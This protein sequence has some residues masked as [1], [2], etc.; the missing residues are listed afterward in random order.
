MLTIGIFSCGYGHLASQ[1]IESVLSQTVMPEQILFFDDGIWD[2]KHLPSIYPELK[3]YF[4]SENVGTVSNFHDALMRVTT[5]YTMFMGADNWLRSDTVE[6]LTKDPADVNICD[7][8]VT[9][10]LKE[11][12][13]EVCKVANYKF[14]DV[15]GD[16]HWHIGDGHHGR[17]M[18]KTSIGKEI[19]YARY[20]NSTYGDAEDYRLWLGFKERNAS[21][22]YITEALLYYRRHRENTIKY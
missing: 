20:E 18:Y 2:C 17:M 6:H 12:F 8:M 4:R 7:I 13:R 19:G 5:E 9:G 14:S 1:A 16:L 21:V 15:N 10:E 3:Y 22:K 11:K